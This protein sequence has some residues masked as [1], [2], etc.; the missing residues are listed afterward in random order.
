MKKQQRF[1][2]AQVPE[3]RS[4]RVLPEMLQR[5]HPLEAINDQ[6]PPR[7]RVLHHHNRHLLASLRQRAQQPTLLLGPTHSQP[8]V[9]Q[10]DLVKLQIQETLRGHGELESTRISSLHTDRGCCS[11]SPHT[12]TLFCPISSFAADR[13][14]LATSP[15]QS[16]VCTP[17]SSCARSQGSR[18]KT[19]GKRSG[20]GRRRSAGVASGTLPSRMAFSHFFEASTASL[21]ADDRSRSRRSMK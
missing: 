20:G 9:A 2:L 10:I 4:H 17:I 8:V 21:A 19:P 5:T 18:P 6:I 12:N 14:T 3:C 1:R 7:R 16:V 15:I 11:L 13:T